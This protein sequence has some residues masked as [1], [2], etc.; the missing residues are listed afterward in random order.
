MLD[1]AG[2]VSHD[3][4]VEKAQQQ[5]ARYDAERA[6]LPSP[7]EAH[8]EEAG[9]EVESLAKTRKRVAPKKKR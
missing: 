5:L 8:F 3:E 1:H 7:V 9:R 4:A 6:E 2:S